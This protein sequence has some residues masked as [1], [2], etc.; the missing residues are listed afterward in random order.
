M[1]DQISKILSST[2]YA[3]ISTVDVDGNPW[4]AP[5]WYVVDD[6]LNMYWW[7][8]LES[9]HSLNIQNNNSVFITLF[10]SSAVEGEG[11]GLYIRSTVTEVPDSEIDT[12][13]ELYN[14]SFM[15]IK[16]EHGECT[17]DAPTRLYKASPKQFWVN[18]GKEVGDFY[19]DYRESIK[20]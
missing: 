14:S 13:L 17:G 16:I 7:S 6:A 1:N 3:T 15:I 18:R 12:A 4:A 20:P 19:I 8:P 9:Q 10:D 5:V 11:L 2:R